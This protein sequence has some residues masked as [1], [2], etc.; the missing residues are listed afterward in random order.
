MKTVTDEWPRGDL[1]FCR[2]IP[3]SPQ[4]W[5]LVNNSPDGFSAT[6]QPPAP[7]SQASR[8]W[9]D[10]R[11]T[12][13]NSTRATQQAATKGSPRAEMAELCGTGRGWAALA[14]LGTASSAGKRQGEEEK[15]QGFGSALFQIL[16]L[17]FAER[18]PTAPSRIILKR[19]R[20][21]CAYHLANSELSKEKKPKHRTF[22]CSVD[23]PK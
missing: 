10:G 4:S 14:R 12:L 21:V 16:V 13:T 3:D 2:I 5:R 1:V 22:A 9:V 8:K 20:R 15:G 7:S 17:S 18:T 23:H 6:P 19:E 11:S